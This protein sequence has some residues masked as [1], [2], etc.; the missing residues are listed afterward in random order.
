MN[1]QEIIAFLSNLSYTQ[2]Y[3]FTVLYFAFLYFGLGFLYQLS[4]KFLC[5][6]NVV[7][8]INDSSSL[9]NR[10]PVEIRY[11]ILSILVFGFSGILMLFFVKNQWVSFREN[12]IFNALWGLVVLFV[13]NEIHFFAMH[14]LLHIPFFYRHVHKIHHQSKIPTVYSVYSFHWIEA[15]LLSAVPFFI[16]PFIHFS[17]AAVGLFPV[18]S[19]LFNFAGHCNY[20]FGSGKGN[21]LG[22]FG[23]RHASHHFRNKGEYGFVTPFMDLLFKPKKTNT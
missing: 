16:V 4:C 13:W 20:R 7:H 15:I 22:Q 19:I 23:T 9:K 8:V 3:L 21:M 1:T 14:R 11:S 5:R 10:I 18:L 12:T 2:A 6:L 17:P